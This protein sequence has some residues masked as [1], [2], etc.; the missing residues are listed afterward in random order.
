MMAV[1][2]ENA[3]KQKRHPECIRM[4]WKARQER[5]ELPTLGSVDR[6]SIQLSYWRA[7]NLLAML[8]RNAE[9]YFERGGEPGIRTLGGAQ[10]PTLA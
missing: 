8:A 2:S 5:L 6:C 7:G 4:P 1:V 10:H 3:M 9:P